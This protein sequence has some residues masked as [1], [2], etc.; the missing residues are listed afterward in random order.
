MKKIVIFMFLVSS[1]FVLSSQAQLASKD[2]TSM[3]SE[4]FLDL[5][6]QQLLSNCWMKM[7]GNVNVRPKEGGRRR[8]A[9]SCAA[10]LQPEKITFKI[11]LNKKQSF[12]VESTFGDKHDTK[13]L[14][15]SRGED[16]DFTKI[17]IKPIDLSLAF[18]YWDYQKE[19]KSESL[20]LS[21]IS[22]RVFLLGDPDSTT[23]VKVWIS[24]KYLGP[25]KVEWYVDLQKAPYQSLTFEDFA[26]TNKVWHPVEVKIKNGKGELQIRFENVNAAFSKV[27]PKGLYE[28]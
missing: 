23:F 3:E 20:G 12:K 14:E 7:K 5:S 28:D 25:L 19:Y 17:G 8:L 6:R 10:Q 11:T 15:D 26:E 22:C 24:E 9:I 16:S 27:T 18:M 1:L 21:R 2:T 4:D 13:V